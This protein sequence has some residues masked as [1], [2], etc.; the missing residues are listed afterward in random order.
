MSKLINGKV[1]FGKDIISFIKLNPLCMAS[2]VLKRRYYVLDG[3]MPSIDP[4]RRYELR[5]YNNNTCYKLIKV[6]KVK[7]HDGMHWIDMPNKTV[8][9]YIAENNL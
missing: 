9:E 1:Y 6:Q 7:K 4:Y 2:I 8:L 3:L 5:I